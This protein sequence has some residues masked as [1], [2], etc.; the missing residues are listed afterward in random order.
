VDPLDEMSRGKAHRLAVAVM[1]TLGYVWLFPVVDSLMGAWPFAILNIQWRYLT[2]AALAPSI[3]TQSLALA[4]AAGFA[5]VIGWRDALRVIA[6]TTLVVAGVAVLGVG[7]HAMDYLQ[8][9]RAVPPDAKRRFGAGMIRWLVQIV[10]GGTVLTVVG[11]S[12]LRAARAARDA[13]KLN[14]ADKVILRGGVPERPSKAG[15]AQQ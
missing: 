11:L 6:I 14:P 2:L 5:W 4:A 9:I 13:I 12:A 3:M 10:S 8:L 1:I 15:R 7:L